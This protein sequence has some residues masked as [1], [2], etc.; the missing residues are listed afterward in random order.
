MKK[1]IVFIISIFSLLCKAQTT[2]IISTL[3]NEQQNEWN[4]AN[5]DKFMSYYW[6]NDS[7]MFIGSKGVTYGWTNTLNNYKKSYP[8]KETM[9][10]LK[11]TLIQINQL[12][13]NAIYV[14]GK[15]QLTRQNP[16]SGHFTLLW[17]KINNNWVIVSDHT[18]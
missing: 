12:S 8:N 14:V 16:I 1:L 11:F 15:W 2:K 6:N 9:G 7:L 3:M 17:K 4:N 5:I 10:V 18:S 13:D